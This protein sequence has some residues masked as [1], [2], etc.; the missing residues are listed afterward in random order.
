MHVRYMEMGLFNVVNIKR[1]VDREDGAGPALR[2]V[3]N[4]PGSHVF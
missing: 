3:Y 1:G 2:V 4:T